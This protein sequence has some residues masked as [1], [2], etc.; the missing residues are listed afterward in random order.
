MQSIY[1]YICKLKDLV[2]I[3][4]I[5]Y[6]SNDIKKLRQLGKYMQSIYANQKIY[7][8]LLFWLAFIVNSYNLIQ[9]NILY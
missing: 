9:I 4:F 8:L 5:F 6:K 2:F 1:I 3:I 7:Y